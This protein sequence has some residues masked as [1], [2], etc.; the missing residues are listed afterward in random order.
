MSTTAAT[1]E[2]TGGEAAPAFAVRLDNFEGP[3]D[4]LLSLIDQPDG[5]VPALL[6]RAG[7]DVATLATAAREVLAKLPRVSG[8]I[9]HS[10]SNE[11]RRVLTE[12]HGL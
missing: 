8:D 4:L 5:V 1:P 10:L 11:A 3:F 9:Q 6:E 12:A 7:V 2:V